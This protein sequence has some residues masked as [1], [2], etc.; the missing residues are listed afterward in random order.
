MAN[1]LQTN[2][3]NVYTGLGTFT[4]TVAQTSMY[5]VQVT[6][7]EVPASSLSIAINQNT[8]NQVT[9][10]APSSAQGSIALRT[11][12]NC[13][14]GDVIDV[15]LSSAAATDNQLNTLKTIITLGRGQ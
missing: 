13:T 14:A 3:A 11:V 7:T 5:Y 8:V 1:T 9:S 2:Q 6:C 15:V 4:H 12:L 10:V